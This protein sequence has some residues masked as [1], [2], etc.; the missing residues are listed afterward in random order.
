M[1]HKIGES[2]SLGRDLP[3]L[4]C[5]HVIE[6]GAS[7][8]IIRRVSKQAG[9]PRIFLV[10]QRTGIGAGGL[11]RVKASKIYSTEEVNACA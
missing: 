10:A 1:R 11:H 2:L 6:A 4:C 8:E 3:T 9:N 7:I 5:T